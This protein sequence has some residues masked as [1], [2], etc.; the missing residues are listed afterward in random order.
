MLKNGKMT[1]QI[2]IVARSTEAFVKDAFKRTVN[3]QYINY[4]AL[5]PFLLSYKLKF[6]AVNA[7][8]RNANKVN[9]CAHDQH[10]LKT[11]H[12][13]SMKILNDKHC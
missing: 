3:S 5:K 11:L 6:G 2:G 1:T 8:S 12:N 9:R 4:F 10:D 13:R 7:L